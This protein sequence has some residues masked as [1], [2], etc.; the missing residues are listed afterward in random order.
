MK[1]LRK[2]TGTSRTILKILNDLTNN[3]TTGVKFHKGEVKTV[4]KLATGELTWDKLDEKGKKLITWK[5]DLSKALD[6]NNSD[7]VPLIAINRLIDYIKNGKIT[8]DES[9]YFQDIGERL[10]NVQLNSN[11]SF[12]TPEILDQIIAYTYPINGFPQSDITNIELEPPEEEF[13]KRLYDSIGFLGRNFRYR[14]SEEFFSL[15]YFIKLSRQISYNW[16]CRFESC[17]H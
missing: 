14:D 1:L 9:Y 5:P 13:A 10:R 3:M 7:V 8:F 15:K 2:H 17:F 12:L 11:D 16:F 6:L 4:Y